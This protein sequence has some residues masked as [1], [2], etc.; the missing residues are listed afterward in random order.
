MA[1]KLP[2]VLRNMNLYVDGHGYAGRIGELTLP[3][4][5]LKT[6]DFQGAGM[7]APVELEMGMEKLEASAT[8]HEYDATTYSVFG[9]SE[10]NQVNII[11]RGALDQD[12]RIVPVNV[13]MQGSWNEIDT[14][15]WKVGEKVE[16][17]I[18]MNLRFYSLSIDGNEVILID[19]EN[20]KRIIHGRD[21]LQDIRTAIGI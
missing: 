12:G 19:I 1:T 20:M 21:A 17:K 11:A 10:G 6:E 9:L 8:L 3:K 16:Q 14:G 7:D 2:Q 4:L 13:T 15:S 5:K 18:S